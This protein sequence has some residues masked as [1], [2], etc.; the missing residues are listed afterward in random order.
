MQYPV[1]E[2]NLSAGEINLNDNDESKSDGVLFPATQ[3]II[4][5]E[6]RA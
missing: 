5:K 1:K 2:F 3:L 4:N 6:G